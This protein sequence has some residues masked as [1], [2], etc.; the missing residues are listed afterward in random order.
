[1]TYI[2]LVNGE[3]IQMNAQ[4]IAERQAEEAAW[5]AKISEPKKVDVLE[6]RL[7][8]LEAKAGITDQDKAAAKAI[9]EGK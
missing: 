6:I 7:A 1:M 3:P 4:E 2:K 8:A 9:L 5:L